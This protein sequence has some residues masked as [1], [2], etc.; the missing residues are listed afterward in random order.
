[1]LIAPHLAFDFSAH[2]FA[3]CSQKIYEA[4]FQLFYK[5][6][7]G[8]KVTSLNLLHYFKNLFSNKIVAL[9]FFF[10]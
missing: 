6:D 7:L 8:K 10:M 4:E 3:Q 5:K 9:L 1:M 2:V